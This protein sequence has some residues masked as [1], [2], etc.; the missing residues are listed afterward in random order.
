MAKLIVIKSL[1][2]IF[3]TKLKG[4]KFTDIFIPFYISKKLDILYP[5]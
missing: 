2:T 5:I 4:K 3:G 1:I